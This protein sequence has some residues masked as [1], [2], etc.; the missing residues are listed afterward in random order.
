METAPREIT[1][2][3]GKLGA[4]FTTIDVRILIA[5][6]STKAKPRSANYYVRRAEAVAAGTNK[7]H[8][9]AVSADTHAIEGYFAFRARKQ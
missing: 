1:L 2:V 7:V 6:G 5:P 3:H 8:W 9:R 4:A